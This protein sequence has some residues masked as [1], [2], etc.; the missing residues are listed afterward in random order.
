ML[1]LL[2]LLLNIS[3]TQPLFF[4]H[5]QIRPVQQQQ[6]RSCHPPFFSRVQ[7]R[8]E[9]SNSGCGLATKKISF[10]PKLYFI[11][12][13]QHFCSV[14]FALL[15]AYFSVNLDQRHINSFCYFGSCRS[16]EKPISPRIYVH[17]KN[18]QKI[19]LRNLFKI[20]LFILY[21]FISNFRASSSTSFGAVGVERDLPAYNNFGVTAIQVWKVVAEQGSRRTDL[22]LIVQPRKEEL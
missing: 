13:A 20:Y 19:L 6:R 15:R 10:P 8:P 1:L 9:R 5:V 18:V 12:F 4:S 21:L 14:F 17:V 3:G 2:L 22:S 11:F 7:V 16:N